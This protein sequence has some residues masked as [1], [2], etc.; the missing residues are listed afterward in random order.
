MSVN[1]SFFPI[2][3]FSQFMVNL[4]LSGSQILGAWSVKLKFSLLIIFLLTKPENRA[5]KSLIWSNSI[6]EQH[7]AVQG[8][9]TI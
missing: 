7:N 6:V 2:I 5:S 8:N 9:S 4:Q 3:V 1:C